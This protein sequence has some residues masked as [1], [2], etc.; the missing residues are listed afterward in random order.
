MAMAFQDFSSYCADGCKSP[1]ARYLPAFT[2]SLARRLQFLLADN[3][4]FSVPRR[5]AWRTDG[6]V[7]TRYFTAKKSTMRCILAAPFGKIIA[8]DI[9]KSDATS[10]SAAMLITFVI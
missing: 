8:A 4:H 6:A 10:T 9:A 7:G 3:T 2:P 1:P 5:L